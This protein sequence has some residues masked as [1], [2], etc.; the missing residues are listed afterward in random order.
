[1]IERRPS[2]E[3]KGTVAGGKASAEPKLTEKAEPELAEKAEP[4]LTLKEETEFLRN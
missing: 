4:E 2:A 1:M 3:P